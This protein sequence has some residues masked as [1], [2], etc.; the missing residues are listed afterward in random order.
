MGIGK[1]FFELMDKLNYRFIDVTYLQTAL[2]HS[3][4]SHEM[5]MKGFRASSNEELEFLGDAVLQLVI[6][7]ELYA[8]FLHN[9]EGA[10]TKMRQKL[11][12]EATL[13][14][15]A[16]KLD[17]GPY[18]NIGT[19]EEA[20]EL[21]SRAKV[22]ADALEAIFAAIYLDDNV[23][24]KG[25][26][27]R[28]VIL[29][30]FDDSINDAFKDGTDDYKTLLQQFVE[31]NGDSVLEYV[32]TELGPEHEKIFNVKAYINNNLVGSGTGQTK[33]AAEMLAAK[34]AL[35]LFGILKDRDL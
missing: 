24:G 13:A 8:R 9:G 33:K 30:L 6:S 20:L 23:N 2:T 4:F 16:S 15:L 11:V 29:S 31:K 3:S 28:G 1:E 26:R 17:I 10:L 18:L 35:G 32:C 21:R 19:G 34:S 22:L 12:C 14:K 5:K 27:Y 7:D 25:L